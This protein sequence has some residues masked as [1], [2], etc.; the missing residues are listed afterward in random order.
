M[1][2]VALS[3]GQAVVARFQQKWNSVDGNK[4]RSF[5]ILGSISSCQMRGLVAFPAEWRLC[6]DTA[7]AVMKVS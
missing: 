4:T 3:P 5:N 6:R 2:I 1:A 7:R